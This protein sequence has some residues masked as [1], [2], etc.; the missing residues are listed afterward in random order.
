MCSRLL[1][2]LGLVGSAVF[3]TACPDDEETNPDAT[4][5]A[6]AGIADQ[7]VA[8]VDGGADAGGEA[9]AETPADGGDAGF[10][11]AAQMDATAMGPVSIRTTIGNVPLPMIPVVFHDSTGAVLSSTVTDSNGMAS[12]DL[13]ANGMITSYG[14][15]L[16][17]N[18]PGGEGKGPDLPSL[19]TIAGVQPGEFYEWRLDGLMFSPDNLVGDISPTLPGTFMGA[20]YYS[21]EF[22]CDDYFITDPTMAETIQVFDR[23][24]GTSTVVDVI[25]Q[26]RDA[27]Y[28][29]IAYS[30]A[31]DVPLASNVPVAFG[32]WDT[33]FV[34]ANLLITGAPPVATGGRGRVEMIRRSSRYQGVEQYGKFMD[35]Q[36]A[37]PLSF[38]VFGDAREV[39]LELSFN[40]ASSLYATRV[41]NAA[42]LTFDFA[43]NDIPYMDGVTF[44]RTDLVR[45]T[46]SWTIG[47]GTPETFF[48]VGFNNDLANWTVVMPPELREMKQPELPDS[49]ASMRP[50][51]TTQYREPFAVFV[52]SDLYPTYDSYRTTL[53]PIGFMGLVV[54]TEMPKDAPIGTELRGA[55]YGSPN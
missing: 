23:C 45:P 7:G 1:F 24:V 13:P 8:V 46:V 42:P 32:P 6:D 18:G 47:N 33:T 39:T 11:D 5:T 10:A 49:L 29:V 17:G 20:D 31:R 14:L 36:F 37:V 21:V 16:F 3:L 40:I 43:A 19:H 28:N 25:A 22:G 54:S 38:P 52:S 15:D 41:D 2:V 12:F 55:A 35:G 44:D 48:M 4:V 50:D 9:D 26:A 34:D 53:G 51:A 30:V 27:N